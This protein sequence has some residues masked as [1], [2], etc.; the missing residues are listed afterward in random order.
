MKKKDE[1]S[2]LVP[3]YFTL[4]EPWEKIITTLMTNGVYICGDK[5][6]VSDDEKDEI[7]LG[8]DFSKVWSIAFRVNSH[9]LKIL[10]LLNPKEMDKDADLSRGMVWGYSELLASMEVPEHLQHLKLPV[11][12]IIR[13]FRSFTEEEE[14]TMEVQEE[15]YW[16]ECRCIGTNEKGNEIYIHDPNKKPH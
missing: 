6:M 14:F 5:V 13:I 7:E 8:D 11:S 16:S 3:V 12:N 2:D 10:Q 4:E 1:I 9:S 15:R